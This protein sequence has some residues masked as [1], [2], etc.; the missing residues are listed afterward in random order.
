MRSQSTADLQTPD[1]QTPDLQTPDLQTQWSSLLG[2]LDAHRHGTTTVAAPAGA[3]DYDIPVCLLTGFLG[4]GKS[5]LLAR[6]LGHPPTGKT[7][8]AVVND[9]GSLRF[10][11]TL[12]SEAG[13]VEVEL[14]NGCGCC[15][16]TDDLAATLDRSAAKRPDQLVLEGS[17]VADPFA[18]AQ[19][20]EARSSLHL[21]RIVTVVDATKV[22][23][24]LS[25]PGYRSIVAR[26]LDAAHCVVL[27]HADRL[28]TNDLDRVT[29]TVAELVPGR[30]IVA[31]S[32]EEIAVAV[33]CPTAQ[34]GSRPMPA[35]GSAS[36]HL[37][38]FEI[39]QSRV[40][41]LAELAAALDRRPLGAVR[42][43][44]CLVLDGTPHD[45]QFTATTSSVEPVAAGVEASGR[46]GRFTLVA[47]S[48]GEVAELVELLRASGT[49][50]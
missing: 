13:P 26:Q 23:L 29:A 8:R 44:G 49:P 40:V 21:D 9:I 45:V 38:T 34:R 1:L 48:R 20:I 3:I 10:D 33:L 32:P 19:V 27:S 35:L 46:A 4:A 42:G 6:L 47:T 25:H 17:G 36:H 43:K 5:T 22:E 2:H 39:E 7:V 18:L 31:S 14:T 28:E 15:E 41:T 12:L 30:I 16:R 37:V 50:R 11:P 24:Q